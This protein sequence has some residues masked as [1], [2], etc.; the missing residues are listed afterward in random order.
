MEKRVCEH[1]GGELVEFDEYG[2]QGWHCPKDCE[3]IMAC[4]KWE[5]DLPFEIEAA[6]IAGLAHSASDTTPI[7]AVAAVKETHCWSCSSTV[8]RLPQY[9]DYPYGHFC[10]SCPHSLRDHP[11]FGVGGSM[12]LALKKPINKN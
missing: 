12:D 2:N 11:I 9:D 10:T 3:F 8:L 7:V 4:K 1:C 6:E 5:E